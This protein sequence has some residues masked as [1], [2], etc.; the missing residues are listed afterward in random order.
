M[1]EQVKIS[2]SNISWSYNFTPNRNWQDVLNLCFIIFFYLFLVSKV[3]VMIDDRYITLIYPMLALVSSFIFKEILSKMFTINPCIIMSGVIFLVLLTGK[4]ESN[5][6]YHDYG[7]NNMRKVMAE[8]KDLP[9]VI[10]SNV[11]HWHPT[12]E[13]ALPLKDFKKNYMLLETE[14]D[15]L[16]KAL[17]E[18]DISKG[19]I[20]LI[21]WDCE[22]KS[23]DILK[24]IEEN[25]GL[26][27]KNKIY[28]VKK[29]KRGEIYELN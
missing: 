24:E 11:K 27:K 9:I 20:V 8:K 4:S 17:S 10:V 23:D 25:T 2:L 29:Y 14:L 22:K 18:V 26:Q 15:K 28:S 3:C 1:G 12:L 21:N 6:K 19:I 13:Y 7:Y 5:L 16:P